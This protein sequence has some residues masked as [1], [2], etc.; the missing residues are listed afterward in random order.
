MR[1]YSHCMPVAAA[2][3]AACAAPVPEVDPVGDAAAATAA[4]N[5]IVYRDEAEPVDAAEPAIGVL[6]GEQAVRAALSHDPRLQEALANARAALAAAS[7]ARRWPNPVLDVMFRF[8]DGGGRTMVDAG[9]SG[10]VLAILQ[11]PTRAAAADQRL[12]A[13]CAQVVTTAID[14]VAEVQ[15]SYAR[16]QA[17]DTEA[18][19]LAAQVQVAQRLAELG[20]ARLAAGDATQLEVAE[21]EAVRVQVEVEAAGRG[22]ERAAERL[23][24]LRL[25]GAPGGEQTFA[26]TPW[27]APPHLAASER[28]LIAVALQRRPELAAARAEV[29][30]LGDDLELA[31]LSWLAGARFGAAFEREDVASVGPAVALPLPVFDDGQA[32]QDRVRAELVGARHRA[33]ARGREV[34]EAV[35]VAVTDAGVAAARLARVND[36]LL[37][38]QQ[39]RWTLA[40]AAWRAGE[41]EV[42]AVLRAEQELR[43]AEGTLLLLQRDVWVARIELERAVGGPAALAAAEQHEQGGKE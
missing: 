10:D 30:A 38:L 28:Q 22:R 33:T 39:R 2:M 6:T 31:G 5:A 15:R 18:P 24:L 1:R 14:V 16:V 13:A 26:L 12:R 41:G 36:E 19:V 7:E 3:L 43:A 17:L 20:R 9:L 37:P 42:G 32:R 29:E 25:L 40:E 4:A 34:V 23:R 21:I 35:R 27:A 11:T 8:P